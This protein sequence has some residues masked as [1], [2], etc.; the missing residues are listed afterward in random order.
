MKIAPHLLLSIL[1]LAPATAR[2]DATGPTGRVKS[3]TINTSGS[4]DWNTHHGA[5][6]IGRKKGPSAVYH[7]GRAYCPGKD[8]T[9][10]QIALLAEALEEGG[11][12]RVTPRYKNGQ[13]GRK[14]L[15]GFTL[16]RGKASA[17]D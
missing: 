6:E 14:C 4:D 16:R 7:F 10:A 3:L 13:A 5:V 15:V 1:L 8:L 11:A 2:A 9:D 12:I 17:A